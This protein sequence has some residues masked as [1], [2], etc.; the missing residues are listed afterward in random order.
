MSVTGLENQERGL[1]LQTRDPKGA[2]KGGAFE[3][4]E[5]EEL[6]QRVT[7]ALRGRLDAAREIVPEK[8]FCCS[9]CAQAF[10]SGRD[11]TIRAIEGE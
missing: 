4:P 11:A 10:T 7:A 5:M 2:K 6:R 1:N 9:H 8:G 3:P